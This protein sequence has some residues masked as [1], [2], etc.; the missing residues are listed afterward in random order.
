MG[1]YHRLNA[2][3]AATSEIRARR[4]WRLGLTNTASRSSA[5]IEESGNSSGIRARHRATALRNPEL[6]FVLVVGDALA[7]AIASWVAPAL[8]AAFDSNYQP[9][10]G[11]P[12][13]QVA[14]IPLWVIALRIADGHSR[15]HPASWRLL[16]S[17]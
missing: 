8:W 12:Y 3:L 9:G 2:P 14:S 13:W 16:T 17:V 4:I 11:V 6:R 10:V 7:A 5:R 15:G 1:T